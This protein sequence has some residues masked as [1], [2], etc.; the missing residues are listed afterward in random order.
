VWFR[1]R[2]TFRFQCPFCG[3]VYFLV[4]VGLVR[5]RF[6]APPVITSIRGDLKC[7]GCGLVTDYDDFVKLHRRWPL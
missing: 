4:N 2:R 7:A 6:D 3:N 5:K 1:R